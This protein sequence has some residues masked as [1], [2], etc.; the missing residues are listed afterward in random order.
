MS[1][2]LP[3][4]PSLDWL[5][6][7]AKSLLKSIKAGDPAILEAIKPFYKLPK[8]PKLADAQFVLALYY[9]F[10]SW[11]KLKA[12]VES[13]TLSE[14]DENAIVASAVGDDNSLA[15]NWLKHSPE[16][17]TTF[18]LA[19]VA[20]DF[21]IVEK[22]L[23]DDPSLALAKTGPL[24]APPIVYLC[25]SKL[26]KSDDVKCMSLLLKLGADPNTTFIDSRFP[27]WPLSILY[28][29]SGWQNN[30]AMTEVLL[31]AGANPTD[32]ESVYHSSEHQDLKCL[33]LLFEYGAEIKGNEFLRVLDWENLEGCKLMLAHGADPNNPPAI[34]HA[35][36]R[37]RSKQIIETLLA[38]GADPN[39]T[40]NA[41]RTPYLVARLYKR[42]DLVGLFEEKLTEIGKWLVNSPDANLEKARQEAEKNP[43]Y[44]ANLLN[45]IASSG[46]VEEAKRVVQL[47]HG[48]S[49][50]NTEGSTPLHQACWNGH[51]EVVKVLLQAGADIEV[52]DGAHNGTPLGWTTHAA[53]IVGHKGPYPQIVQLLLDAG[54]EVK[55]DTYF[56]GDP[57]ID[58]VIQDHLAKTGG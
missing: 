25:F 6:S 51:I 23:A 40:D 44:V 11:P 57:E 14:F 9:G 2:Q 7:E 8:E 20:G 49:M 3:K 32:G 35:I 53:V 18:L 16:K 12:E 28:G 43:E 52:R 17:F 24:E 29:A 13:R 21:Q 34:V 10:E 46:Q 58:K 38:A 33:K 56:E 45:D 30:P 47:E 41:G 42:A 55:P 39:Q 31:K 19:I 15:K 22:Y 4:S 1:K 37:G 48:L 5:R 27:D 36:R 26:K 54:A 50:R